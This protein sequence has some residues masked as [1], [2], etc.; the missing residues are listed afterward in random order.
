MNAVHLQSFQHKFGEYIRKQSHDD[1]DNMP[2][3]VGQLYQRLIYNNISGFIS[4]CFPICQQVM[5]DDVWQKL[6]LSFIKHGDMASP[7]F[8]EINQQFVDYLQNGDVI[9]LL[10]LPAFIAE[11][12]HYEWIELYVDNLPNV[13][14]KLFLADGLS[15][16]GTLQVLHY[17]YAV[18]KMSVDYLPDD[19][20]ETFILVYRQSKDNQHQTAFMTINVISFIILTFIQESDKVYNDMMTLKNDIVAYFNLDNALLDNM[21]SLFDTL[22]ENQV[23]FN[24]K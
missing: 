8:S 15:L 22:I 19:C 4:Q 7:Y 14:P 24:H 18:D 11:L 2:S 12:A 9:D 5:D 13:E 21:E 10:G 17:Q 23:M 6:L 3:R 1:G 20:Q 16:N